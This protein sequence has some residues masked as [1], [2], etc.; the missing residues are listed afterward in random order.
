MKKLVILLGMLLSTYVQAQATVELYAEKTGFALYYYQS[1]AECTEANGTWT[2]ELCFFEEENTI[3][4]TKSETETSVEINTWG[5]NGHSCSFDSKN[6]YDL[7]TELKVVEAVEAYD[8]ESGEM[9]PVLCEVTMTK[10]DNGY[11]VT[12]NS[13]CQYFCGARAWLYI[14]SATKK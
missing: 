13:N 10:L 4:I 14:D 7:G 9:K 12:N 8:F 5:G 2:D 1:E 11:S 3:K 6:V